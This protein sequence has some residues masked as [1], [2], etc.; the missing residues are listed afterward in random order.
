MDKSNNKKRL[1]ALIKIL[2]KNT[3]EDKR[4]KLPEIV[5]LLKE[6]GIEINNRKTLY[7]DFKILN[8]YDINVEYDDG[9]YV[10]EAPFNLSEIKIIQDSI[11]SLKNLDTK[12]LNSLNSKLYTFISNDEVKLLEKLKYLNKHRDTK[13]LQHMEDIISAIKNNKSVI[14]RTIDQKEI[15]IFPL[16]IHREN[17]YYYF[18]YHYENSSKLY[19]YRFDNIKDIKLTDRI[20]TTITQIKEVTKAIEESSKSYSLGNS[21]TLRIV[22]NKQDDKLIDRFLDDFPGSFRTKEGF[23]LK[24]DI[25]N[26]FFSKLAAYKND[27]RIENKDISKKYKQYLESILKL[28]KK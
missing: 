27:I 3:N 2:R 21:E 16:F 14:A 24:A 25:N 20:D 11:N 1:L 12:L 17:D 23:A 19:H 5:N 4:L 10:L 28:Y 13:L 22:L 18:Y 7:D 6:E 15:E 9:Y 8:E 26:I